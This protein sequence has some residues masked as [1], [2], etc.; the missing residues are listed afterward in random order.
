ME[1]KTDKTLHLL[2]TDAPGPALWSC[3]IAKDKKEITWDE[4]NDILTVKDER[5]YTLIDKMF[6]A[7]S[8]MFSSKKIHIGMDEA[9]ALGRGKLL[10]KYGLLPRSKIM[11]S[12]L[13]RVSKLAQKYDFECDIWADMLWNSY[14]E[15]NDKE[16]FKMQI[17]ENITLF[18]KISKWI[19]ME[20]LILFS[21]KDL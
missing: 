16:H 7:V 2:K 4:I 6:D 19:G 1:F 9:W 17:P 10:D 15:S 12:H 20:F 8:K 18:W 11:A 13:K 14:H 5:V 3:Y 21:F